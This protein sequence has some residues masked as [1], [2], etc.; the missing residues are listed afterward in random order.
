MKKRFSILTV[1]IVTFLAMFL[2]M[3][4]NSVISGDSIF[5]QINKFKDVLSAAEKFY[6]DDIDTHKMVESAIT[7]ML[8]D[9][10]PHSVYIPASQ[11]PKIQ[12]DFQGSFEGIGVEY[13][14]INDTLQVQLTVSGG[15]SEL[16]GIMSGDKIVKI[17]DSS[18]IG[19]KT[20]DVPKKLR[21][22]K[23][24]HVKV[25]IYRPGMKDLIDF[26]IVRDKIPLYSIDVAYMVSDDIAYVSV[27][28]FSA[29]TYSELMENLG[30]LR[31][32]G[33]KKLI[34]DLRNNG[35][36]YLEQAYKMA[37]E[38]L[39]K[40]KKIVYTK[41]RRAEFN[42]E[43]VSQGGSY[44]DVSLIVLVNNG[45]ASASEI[46]SGA[47]QDWDRGLIV[48]ETTFG[49][50]LVQRQFPL[51]DN[52]AF[53][54]TTARYY[55]PSG[56]LIQRPYGA[57]KEKYRNEA[58]EREEVEGEN[59]E[60]KEESDST[61]PVF[62]TGAGRKVF[63]GGGITPDYIVKAGKL[64]QFSVQLLAKGVFQEF[65]VSYMDRF[66]K[67]LRQKYQENLQGFRNEFIVTPEMVK[68]FEALAKKKEVKMDDEQYSKDKL[69]IETRIKAQIARGIWGNEGWYSVM[70]GEDLQ[71]QKAMTLFPE[72]EK[73]ARLQ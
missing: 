10:D 17:N 28:R 65:T 56:R 39:P 4:L 60:H 73:I 52:S 48:G 6:V 43:Y 15:P 20:E 25:S 2:G 24:T 68:D 11:L 22:Q 8:E 32:Q 59:I 34:L 29:T 16:I 54:L 23:G 35:G 67:Q 3:Q 21:G 71:Y 26:D 36:G 72:A 7:G 38:L 47:I 63:G 41:G 49:K 13:A 70:R 51:S 19:I 53:R 37:D 50:G 44:T 14:V 9:L 18:A 55:T 58:F 46:V 12:E 5:E 64:T 31:K 33:M 27:N 57:D 62:K 61:R 1:G 40:G 30:K 45:S 66:G 69:Y 42:E